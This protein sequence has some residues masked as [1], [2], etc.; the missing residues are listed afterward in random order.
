[1]RNMVSDC[2]DVFIK[3]VDDLLCTMTDGEH[4]RAMKVLEKKTEVCPFL[5][6]TLSGYRKKKRLKTCSVRWRV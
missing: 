1:M 6:S 4:E 3:A 5:L 2:S